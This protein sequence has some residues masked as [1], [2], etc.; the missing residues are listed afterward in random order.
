MADPTL[1][2]N[3]YVAFTTSTGSSTYVVLSGVK[4]LGFSISAAEL[5]D[6]VM[7]D[8]LEAKYPGIFSVPI[9]ITARQDFTSAVGG[10]DKFVHT[11]LAART[12]FKMKIRPVNSAV[13]ATNPSYILSKG[14]FHSESPL[15]GSHGSLL[16]NKIEFRAQSGCTITRSTST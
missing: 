16:E 1:F 11:R 8:T 14:R 2:N 5:D 6:A 10:V 15:D 13:S 7:G 4:S 3:A 9:S 12:A